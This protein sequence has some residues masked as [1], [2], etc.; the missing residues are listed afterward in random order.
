M[1]WTLL[2]TKQAAKDAVLLKRANLGKRV[3]RLFD[4]LESDPY[5][6]PPPYEKLVGDLKGCYSRRINIH[7]RLVYDVITEEKVVRVLR[8]W[9]HY[10]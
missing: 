10:E 8:M 1:A 5:Q 6:N 7:H 9:S 4:V 3:K 2:F